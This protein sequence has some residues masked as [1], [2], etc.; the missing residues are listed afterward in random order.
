MRAE[1]PTVRWMQGREI[2]GNGVMFGPTV[3]RLK[4]KQNVRAH[5]RG[6]TDAQEAN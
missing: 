4:R 3:Q 2:E 6:A 5:W 1:N